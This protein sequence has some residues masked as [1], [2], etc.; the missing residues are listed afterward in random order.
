MRW[1]ASVSLA[2]FV[3]IGT[4]AQESLI[5]FSSD[6]REVV[7]ADK[8]DGKVNLDL[9]PNVTQKTHLFVRNPTGDARDMT[10]R[11]KDAGGKQLAET[12]IKAVPNGQY[13]RVRFKP[14]PPPM[15]GAVAP[16]PMPMPMAPP[17][18]P[19]IELI[20]VENPK[21]K[22]LEREFQIVVSYVD[23]LKQT[24]EQKTSVL[25]DIRSPTDY[26]TVAGIRFSKDGKRNGLQVELSAKENF[27]P[28]CPVE[29]RFPPQPNLR[30][31]ALRAGDYLR[32]LKTPTPPSREDAL[33]ADLSASNL[34][35]LPGAKESGT[36]YVNIDGVPRA[37]IFK[38]AFHVENPKGG[39]VPALDTSSIHIIETNRDRSNMPIL[40]LPKEQFPLRIEADRAPANSSIELQ[41][42]RGTGVL[43]ADDIHIRGGT[44]QE[45]VWLEPFGPEEAFIVTT[46]VNDWVIPLDTRGMRGVYTLKAI[47]NVQEG[48]RRVARATSTRSFVLDD[49]PPEEVSID[50]LPEKHVRTL[51]LPVRV[52]AG[53]PESG[54]SKVAVFL[55]KPMPDGK[56]PDGIVMVAAAKPTGEGGAWVAQ[57]PL[58]PD[59][60]G[61]VDLTAVA[62][63][64]V[65]ITAVQTQIVQL[66]DP[67]Q[68][69][70]IKGVVS[71]GGKAQAGIK[72]TLFNGGGMETDFA[73][74]DAKGNFTMNNV[75]PG[76]YKVYAFKPD[77]GDGA[78][79]E[80][81]VKVEVGKIHIVE[82]KLSRRP[83]PPPKK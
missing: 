63:N 81:G 37:Y 1:F 15:P 11:L 10:V 73:T 18:P 72:V 65:G 14:P 24:I 48:E 34:P 45:R 71:F 23:N 59:K 16:A 69:G 62:T 76:P 68:G 13:A 49:T 4:K 40:S 21:T 26:V 50:K 30:A 54:I 53:D 25:V 36:V 80:E 83:L 2:V 29:L 52:F 46:K 12:V 38:P 51:P 70:T 67:P 42:D 39:V 3:V 17:E 32:L 22:K 44:R 20:A 57:V 41:L 58:P 31:D 61:A 55:G 66:L 5:R 64:G 75:L 28:P 9:R 79:G 47:L 74:T 82:I 77:A 27:D 7:P 60:K 6:P 78:R 43:S 19:G 35:I 33:R 8:L 56:L